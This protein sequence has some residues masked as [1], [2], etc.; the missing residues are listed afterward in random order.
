MEAYMDL[1]VDSARADLAAVRAGFRSH[2]QYANEIWR[3]RALAKPQA[4]KSKA[5]WPIRSL[6]DVALEKRQEIE[7]KNVIKFERFV[8]EMANKTIKK[9]AKRR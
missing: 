9:M 7:R 4:V 5:N 2:K 6:N 8:E 3:R 1:D